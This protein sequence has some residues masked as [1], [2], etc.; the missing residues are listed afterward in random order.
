MRAPNSTP[1][2]LGLGTD[3]ALDTGPGIGAGRWDTMGTVDRTARWDLAGTVVMGASGQDVHQALSRG[4]VR[5]R[6]LTRPRN[7]GRST[8]EHSCARTC[9]DDVARINSY[10]L[11][12]LE[13]RH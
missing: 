11:H 12:S 8:E 4:H 13:S 9:T 1:I 5:H 3:M 2:G 10:T 6:R 7:S